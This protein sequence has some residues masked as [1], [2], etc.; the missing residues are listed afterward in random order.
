MAMEIIMQD[1]AQFEQLIMQYTQIKNGS[2]EIARLLD[3]EDFDNAMAMIKQR[4]P[5]FLNC[6]CMRK[7]LELTPE[8]QVELDKLLDEIRE[9]ELKNIK[10]LENNMNEVRQLL[11][12]NKKIEKLHNT[13]AYNENLKG[14][15][16]NFTE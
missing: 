4:E 5:L 6:K 2:E 1:Q 11:K 16:A 14:S 15:I 7:Y 12:T 8:Q 9:L 10:S 13:Y 3:N